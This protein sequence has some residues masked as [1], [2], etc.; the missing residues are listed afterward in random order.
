M[1]KFDFM[2]LEEPDVTEGDVKPV[3]EEGTPTEPVKE[4]VKEEVVVPVTDEDDEYEEVEVTIGEDGK[5]IETVIEPVVKEPVQKKE[6]YTEAEIQDIL[7]ID[8]EIDTSRLSPAEQAT[9]KAMQRGFTPKLQEAA[10]LRK[11]VALLREQVKGA[12]P[13]EQPADIFA[14]YD[15][16]PDGVL[17]YVDSQIQEL[18]A[19]GDAQDTGAI[20]QLES[21]KFDF[22]RRDVQKLREQAS[23]RNVQT[24]IM[25]Q[26]MTTVPD[27]AAKQD[28]L[29]EFALTELGYTEQELAN[30]TNPAV[31]GI[32]AARAIARINTAYDKAQ[33]RTTVRRKR[34]KIPTPVEKPSS[35]GFV[36]PDTDELKSTKQA[37]L[38]SGN[39][40]DYFA[41]LEEE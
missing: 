18:V 35:S 38:D 3:V 41:A 23:T 20:R 15:E 40:S 29:K 39:F 31:A 24:E 32:G 5:E 6:P 16:D 7:N 17:R 26:I 14:A 9:M 8:G 30:E 12:K 34:K 1:A 27:L 2:S 28:K 33:A 25:S 10:E 11:E 13:V 4:E 36:K 19:T 22:N 37:A 21:L